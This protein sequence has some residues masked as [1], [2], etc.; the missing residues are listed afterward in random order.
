MKKRGITL[1]EVMVGTF[2]LSLISVPLYYVLKTATHRRAMAACKEFVKQESNKVF[3][4]LEQDLSQARRE[5][6]KQPSDEVFEIEVRK[7]EDKDAA[8]RYVYLA[9]DLKRQYDGKEWV[10]S[11]A[12]EDFAITTSPDA[13]GRLVVSLKTKAWFDG[14]KEEEA[15]VLAQE[16]MIVM[17]ED[18]A[19]EKDQHWRDVGDVNKFFA[20]QGSIMAGV[21]ED[22][23][24]L[25]QDFSSEWKD[26][27]KDVENMTLG[28]L[29][30]IKEDLF[31]GLKDVEESMKGIDKDIVDL[32]P[33]ALFDPNCLGKL[34]DSKKKRAKN[35]KNAL[36][37]MDT[38]DKMDW[39]KIKEVGGGSSFFSSGMKTDA[40]K[41]F[42]NAKMELFNSG[43]EIVS[44]IDSFA[45]LAKDKGLDVDTSSIDRNKW[46]A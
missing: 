37:A 35:V 32:D 44:Q 46:G 5:S 2:I 41:E 8:L 28:E 23:K 13:P 40:I 20:T 16:K 17:R 26:A 6:F 10:V 19:F 38:K 7:S 43:Q 33:K 3:K 14:V 18:A 42:Y 45:E 24:Q 30:K 22:A 36:A 39:N 15:P 11:K 34:S 4:I 25:V 9:P 29:K 27:M 31:S 21:K 1:I 12:V